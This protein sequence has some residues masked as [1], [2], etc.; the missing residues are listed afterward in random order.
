MRTPRRPVELAGDTPLHSDRD[1]V[2]LDG[3]EERRPEIVVI[4]L[5]TR[6]RNDARV[7]EGGEKEVGDHK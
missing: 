5:G 6:L 7:H 4:L 1:A 3:L 2:H